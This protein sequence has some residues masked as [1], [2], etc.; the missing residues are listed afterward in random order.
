MWKERIYVPINQTLRERAIRWCHDEPMAG[1]PGIAKTLELT[2]RT[3]WWPNMQKDIEKY[4]KACHECQISKPD[5]EPRAAPLQPNEIPLEPW[6]VISIDLIGPLVP[7]KG[8]DMIL[9][10]ID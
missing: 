10:I 4:I 9:V 1:H 8:K 3:F 2:T 6:A 7:S 5:R